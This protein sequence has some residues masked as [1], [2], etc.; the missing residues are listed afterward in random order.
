MSSVEGRVQAFFGSL[1]RALGG[2]NEQSDAVQAELRAD[3]EAQVRDAVA[4]GTGRDAAWSTALE[5][6]GEPAALAAAMR[7]SLP[8][9]PPRPWLRNLRMIGAGL[10]AVW[11]LSILF[12]WRSTDYGMDVR[13]TLLLLGAHLPLVLLLWPGLVWRW[14][15]LFSTG[16]SVVFVLLL[17]AL[18]V[19]SRST[20]VTDQLG[21]GVALATPG[22]GAA[23]NTVAPQRVFGAIDLVPIAFAGL[24]VAMFALLQRRRQRWLAIAWTVALLAPIEAVHQVEEGLFRAEA[25]HVTAWIQDRWAARGRLPSGEEFEQ[26]Y[27]PRWLSQLHYYPTDRSNPDGSPGWMLHWSRATERSHELLYRSDGKIIGND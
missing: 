11:A 2:P 8:P 17:V 1:E 19:W 27:Q 26:D 10:V 21:A 15:P 3:L 25:R 14:N 9:A 7:G 6:M 12:H 24:I 13:M 22:E 16:A 18:E 23:L 5:S 4:A 20:P